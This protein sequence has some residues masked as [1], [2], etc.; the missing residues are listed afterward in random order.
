MRRSLGQ[1]TPHLMSTG[2]FVGISGPSQPNSWGVPAESY[3]T[4]LDLRQH[5]QRGPGFLVDS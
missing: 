1:S 3:A 5:K 4:S 2:E